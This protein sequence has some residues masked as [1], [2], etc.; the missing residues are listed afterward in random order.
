MKKPIAATLILVVAL[1]L[2]TC[3]KDFDFP[4]RLP[5]NQVRGFGDPNGPAMV[6]YDQVNDRLEIYFHKSY[7]ENGLAANY[8]YYYLIDSV[9]SDRVAMEDADSQWVFAYVPATNIRDGTFIFR[10]GTDTV[11][12]NVSGSILYNP[13]Y[14]ALL[15]SVFGSN[16]P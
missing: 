12:A 14:D 10:F 5:T 4:N 2:V 11:I 3:K 8:Y 9:W 1:V 16:G 6:Y 7:A 13:E 15:V